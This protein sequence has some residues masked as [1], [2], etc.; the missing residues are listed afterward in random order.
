MEFEFLVWQPSLTLNQQ[1]KPS[2]PFRK[3]KTSQMSP[4]TSI[5]HVEEGTFL[6]LSD[7]VRYWCSLQSNC[8]LAYQSKHAQSPGNRNFSICHGKSSLACGV[9]HSCVHLFLPLTC[10]SQSLCGVLGDELGSRDRAANKRNA[11]PAL[12]TQDETQPFLSL[13]FCSR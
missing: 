11:F 2:C 12:Q 10:V 1:R 9:D 5:L 7:N 13:L 3:T 4:I 8:S 6:A